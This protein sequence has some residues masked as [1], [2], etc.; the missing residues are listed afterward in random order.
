[1]HI[2]LLPASKKN[3]MEQNFENQLKTKNIKPTAMRILVLKEISHS[4]NA[5]NF[6]EL[7]QKFDKVERSTLYRTLKVFEE[8]HL[9]HPISDGTG[10]VKYAVCKNNCNCKPEELHVH[11][12]CTQCEKTICLNDIPIPKVK[13]PQNYLVDTAT[14]LLKG[15]CPECRA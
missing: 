7:E 1:M 5:I 11:F 2:R 8:A 6:Y 10:S 4:K 9:I 13:L 15:I 3:I 12:F 14:Y